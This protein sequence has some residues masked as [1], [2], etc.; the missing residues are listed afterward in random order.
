[1][2]F[3][4]SHAAAALAAVF[5]AAGLSVAQ[6]TTTLYFRQ[7]PLSARAAAVGEAFVADVQSVGSAAWNP[8]SLVY[9]QSVSVDATVG[10]RMDN[11]AMTGGVTL[12]LAAREQ[13]GIAVSGYSALFDRADWSAKT[14]TVYGG[15]MSCAA[16]VTPTFS[17]GALYTMQTGTYAG[18]TVTGHNFG[19]GMMYTALPAFTYGAALTGIGSGIVYHQTDSV[20]SI[21]RQGELPR[22]ITLGAEWHYPTTHDRIMFN[23]F[24]AGEKII[25]VDQVVYRMGLEIL[26]WKFL[27][28]R[29]GVVSGPI[30]SV[31]RFGFGIRTSIVDIDYAVA[32]SRAEDR[33]HSVT[34]SFPIFIR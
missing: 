31:G 8:A 10:A 25:G 30:T 34:V 23:Y 6:Q 15:T 33:V 7:S 3:F 14:G 24:L 16:R 12:P 9:L 26:P 29:G 21:D 27:A 5:L 22:S 20:R 18:T 2:K 28:I 32:S 1:M 4:I 11:R 19:I 17:V 13:Y